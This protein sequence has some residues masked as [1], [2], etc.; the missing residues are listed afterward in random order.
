MKAWSAVLA[1]LAGVVV[2]ILSA[3]L[4]MRYQASRDSNAKG[5][6]GQTTTLPSASC[7]AIVRISL[8]KDS[9]GNPK[10]FANPDPVCLAIGRPL[11]WE[12]VNQ[13]EAKGATIEIT[14]N[15]QN[16]GFKGPFPHDPQGNP[17]NLDIGYYKHTGPGRINSNKAE[18][19]N[20]WIYRLKWTLTNATVV[21]NDDP[22]VC[23][24]D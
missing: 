13:A 5:G 16:G 6:G 18:K 14:F 8:G 22:V 4:G 2:A 12:V 9:S 15:E 21:E 7:D 10:I 23:I 19:N 20:R 17:E 11:T 3:Y 24:R 1:V